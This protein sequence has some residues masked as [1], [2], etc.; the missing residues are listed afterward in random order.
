MTTAQE[1]NL[2]L[3]GQVKAQEDQIKTM[4]E[5]EE[6]LHSQISNLNETLNQKE[7]RLQDLE[8]RIDTM[9]KMT[10]G[11]HDH[12]VSGASEPFDDINRIDSTY[13]KP[14]RSISKHYARAYLF[15]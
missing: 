9:H 5:T 14:T 6:N 12:L 15:N 1:E 8:D 10:S 4:T 2:E 11:I 13:A 3:N 7:D